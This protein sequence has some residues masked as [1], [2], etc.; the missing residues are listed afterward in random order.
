MLPAIF[1]Q[2]T[3]KVCLKNLCLKFSN[4]WC[5]S[6][7]YNISKST[8]PSPQLITFKKRYKISDHQQ[9]YTISSA[10]AVA[11]FHLSCSHS[12]LTNQ[13]SP[14]TFYQFTSTNKSFSNGL[15]SFINGVSNR[16]CIHQTTFHPAFH[17]NNTVLKIKSILVMYHPIST[18]SRYASCPH[19]T[20]RHTTRNL[21]E[22][23]VTWCSGVFF[24]PTLHWTY[25]SS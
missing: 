22:L 13:V 7:M 19:L 5:F 16:Y 11:T 4:H 23:H 15:F 21:N 12:L 14:I 20:S 9:L 18:S 10:A 8:I 25:F 6:I 2:S 3:A 24:I 1:L 17:L